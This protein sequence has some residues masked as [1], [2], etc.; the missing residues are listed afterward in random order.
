[1][2]PDRDHDMSLHRLTLRLEH[3]GRELMITLDD[4][5]NALKALDEKVAAAADREAAE[6]N[7][8]QGIMDQVTAAAAKVDALAGGT[9]PAPAESASSVPA[10]SAEA[11]PTETAPA[12]AQPGHASTPEGF[13]LYTFDGDP[14]TVDRSVYSPYIDPNT[15]AQ[16]VSATGAQLFT[17]TGDHNPGDVNGDTAPYHAAPG[18]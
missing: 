3:Y 4:V 7:N 16:A 8:Y 15:G 10:A 18:A 6:K 9:A 5:F 14:A 17:F 11:A 2:N 13:T 1:M 12:A